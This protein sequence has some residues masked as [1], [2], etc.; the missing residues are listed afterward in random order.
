[1]ILQG[2]DHVFTS[3]VYS[4]DLHNVVVVGGDAGEQCLW[5]PCYFHFTIL[6]FNGVGVWYYYTIGEDNENLC[7]P[8]Q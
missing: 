8:T 6:Q 4:N 3:K 7:S 1:M 5:T 2:K